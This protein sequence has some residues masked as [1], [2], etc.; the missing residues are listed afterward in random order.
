MDEILH[1]L[2]WR[3]PHFQRRF[4]KNLQWCRISDINSSKLPI[5]SINSPFTPL[6]ITWLVHPEKY[7][8]EK[9]KHLHHPPLGLGVPLVDFPG[10]N[11]EVFFSIC[12]PRRSSLGRTAQL[13]P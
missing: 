4:R 1:Q 6:N 5:S 2:I 11:F 7:E 10:C 8:I 12:S 3:I 9:E 13:C